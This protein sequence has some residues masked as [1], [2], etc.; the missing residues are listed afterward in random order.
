MMAISLGS[1]GWL[2]QEGLTL[3]RPIRNYE[4]MYAGLLNLGDIIRLVHQDYEQA[5]S[6]LQEGLLLARKIGQREWACSALVNLAELDIDRGHYESANVSLEECSGEAAKLNILRLSS[7]M[8]FYRGVVALSLGQTEKA[9][10]FFHELEQMIPDD[11]LELQTLLHYGHARLAASQ[12]KM[13]QAQLLAE[14]SAAAFED[15]GNYR[16]REIR[17][18]LK[19]IQML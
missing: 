9:I 17:R 13:E 4:N 16:F 14:A 7:I 8:T 18:W 19:S 1:S 2:M 3:A 11:D 12:G 6:L 10:A 15:A 5:K